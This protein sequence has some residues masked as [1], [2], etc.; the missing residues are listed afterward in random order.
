MKKLFAL[1]LAMGV[2]LALPLDALAVS[3]VKIPSSPDKKVDNGDGTMTYYYSISLAN[4]DDEA[5]QEFQKVELEFN[6]GPAITSF[7]CGNN[8]EFTASQTGDASLTECV[9]TA[10]AEDGVKGEKIEL[11]Q[12]VVIV[13]KNAEDKD[14]TI[15]YSYKGAEGKVTV[16][17]GSSVPYMIITGGIVLGAAVYFATKKKSKLQRI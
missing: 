7:T 9:Y 2:L 4:T 3:A 12:L 11:G 16:N 1:L 6:Y 8:D 13:K 14:C 17:T 5:T 10:K 15:N